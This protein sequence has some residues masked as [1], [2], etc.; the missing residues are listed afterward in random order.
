MIIL[1]GL[2]DGVTL[3]VLRVQGKGSGGLDE[4]DDRLISELRVSLMETIG[5]TVLL[6]LWPL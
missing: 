1:K 6:T 5:V 4:L 2:I 3:R